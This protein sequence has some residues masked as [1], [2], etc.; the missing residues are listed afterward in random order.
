M[1]DPSPRCTRRAEPQQ[2]CES[3]LDAFALAVPC[4]GCG[5]SSSDSGREPGFG[6]PHLPAPQFVRTVGEIPPAPV[7]R[8]APRL[9]GVMDTGGFPRSSRGHKDPRGSRPAVQLSL[10]PV[11][12][13][14]T[15]LRRSVCP[16]D[17]ATTAVAALDCAS[18]RPRRRQPTTLP[19]AALWMAATYHA[20]TKTASVMV[21]ARH[22]HDGQCMGFHPSISVLLVA[23]ARTEQKAARSGKVGLPAF[24]FRA[25]LVERNHRPGG[26]P[27]GR[28]T[29][30]GL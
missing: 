24:F 30:S 21:V 18:R 28:V 14:P 27:G 4:G 15:Y 16:R 19:L 13:G 10:H 8:H 2:C 5:V 1:G 7:Q 9:G 12:C 11:R 3:A 25:W 29:S 6:A 23:L 22:F 20:V 17:T 26:T